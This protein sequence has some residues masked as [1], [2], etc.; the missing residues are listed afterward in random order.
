MDAGGIIE[1]LMDKKTMKLAEDVLDRLSR[2]YKGTN[3]GIFIWTIRAYLADIESPETRTRMAAVVT[4]ADINPPTP[5]SPLLQELLKEFLEALA[6]DMGASLDIKPPPKSATTPAAPPAATV[7]LPTAPG[8]AGKTGTGLAR[9]IKKTRVSSL[10]ESALVEYGQ[11]DRMDEFAAG[12]VGTLLETGA[13]VCVVASPPMARS[14]RRRFGEKVRVVDLLT[15]GEP[16]MDD[17]ISAIP[18]TNLEYF[19]PV[20]SGLAEGGV[21]VF[22]PLS[23]LAMNIGV[24]GTYKFISSAI[25]Q[26]SQRGVR[27]IAF[28]NRDAHEAKE[29][30]SFENLFIGIH[31][32]EDVEVETEVETEGGE[33]EG[34]P[35]A[36]TDTGTGTGTGAD[37]VSE[38]DTGGPG[39]QHPPEPDTAPEGG[40][41]QAQEQEQ[42]RG[43][44]PDLEQGS[45]QGGEGQTET[46]GAA[47]APPADGTATSEVA[48]LERIRSLENSI[49]AYR[50]RVERLIAEKEKIAKRNK[51]LLEKE[52]IMKRERDDALAEV[53]RCEEE[54]VTFAQR[55]D[56]L[57]EWVNYEVATRKREKISGMLA[58]MKALKNCDGKARPG[59]LATYLGWKRARVVRYMYQTQDSLMKLGLVTQVAKGTYGL[60]N[61]SRQVNS[62]HEIL[63]T[64]L[65]RIVEK[66]MERIYG[67]SNPAPGSTA[68]RT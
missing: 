3:K 41:G 51:E 35:R 58:V 10:G 65:K 5:I 21:V 17:E 48:L 34:A 39:G 43:Q 49:Q 18:M 24:D 12:L 13:E 64:I 33:D 44:E 57:T 52:R 26:L 32:M 20:F 62:T 66:E 55:L 67:D 4:G 22:E 50:D 23:H 6:K 8:N 37:V 1:Q 56:S 19:R 25:D 15:E 2:K 28:L 45:A 63:E 60:T 7:S 38:P 30:S 61:I 47:P 27:F 68:P 9:S 53:K 40:Q 46:G 42:Q 36:Q 59:E 29:V 14:H 11:G 16:P 54:V 31:Q